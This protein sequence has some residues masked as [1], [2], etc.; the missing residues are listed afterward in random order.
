LVPFTKHDAEHLNL[1][2]IFHY[3][4]AGLTIFAGCF[5]LT[6]VVLG[7]VMLVAPSVFEQPNA[8]SDEPLQMVGAFFMG[9]GGCIILVAW[10]LAGIEF[11]AGRYLAAQRNYRFC[12]VVAAINCI[13]LPIGT[14]LGILTLFVLLRPSVKARF[15]QNSELPPS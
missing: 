9:I 1:L 14:V 13:W 8:H 7:V 15:E 11:L 10:A 2:S 12:T 6:Y 4:L 3:V 5:P